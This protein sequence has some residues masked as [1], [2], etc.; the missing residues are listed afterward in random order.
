MKMQRHHKAEPHVPFIAL[1]DIGWQV[2]IFFLVA[3]SFTM[4]DALNVDLPSGTSQAPATN[5]TNVSILASESTLMLDGKNLPLSD[6]ESELKRMLEGKTTDQGKG[7]VVS[8]KDD[9]TFQR[10][11]EIL[12]AIQRAGGLV[13]ISEET[14]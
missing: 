3:A 7:V 11:A 1:A 12:W 5:E 4:N 2:I 8:Y 9:V 10:N 14:Q 6:L 13:I